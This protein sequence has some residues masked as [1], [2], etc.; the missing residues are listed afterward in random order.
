MWFMVQTLWFRT[1]QGL[2][3]LLH[4]P[5]GTL[6]TKL[7]TIMSL[8]F[9]LSLHIVGNLLCLVLLCLIC[10]RCDKVCPLY[11]VWNWGYTNL[12]QPPQNLYGHVG[13]HCA[14]SAIFFL[15][16]NSKFQMVKLPK[17]SENTLLI[18]FYKGGADVVSFNS[19]K[20]MSRPV[21]WQGT[22]GFLWSQV[23]I[24]LPESFKTSKTR[25]FMG[26]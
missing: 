11:C 8:L 18:V 1:K 3:A 21:V 20:I 25:G 14:M 15:S 10:M 4:I 5:W 7:M 23:V 22:C 9:G 24:L 12:N 2:L 26:T 16:Q 6:P 19:H 17:Y 13:N